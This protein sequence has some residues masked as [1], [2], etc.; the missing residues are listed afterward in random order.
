MFSILN[1]TKIEKLSY[2]NIIHLEL[3]NNLFNKMV[4]SETTTPNTLS[5]IRDLEERRIS[6]SSD[7][8]RGDEETGVWS[9]K[10]NITFI[11]SRMKGYGIGLITFVRYV[12][13]EIW[14]VLDGGNRCRALRDFYN[15]VFKWDGKKYDELSG[16]ERGK[17]DY[18]TM[19]CEKLTIE[20]GDPPDT[21][22]EMFTRLNTSSKTLSAGELCKAHGYRRNILEIEV[23]KKIVGGDA[24]TNSSVTD[25][26]IDAIRVRW[27]SIMG[28]IT[29]GNRC[30]SLKT[31]IG[32]IM[33]AILKKLKVFSPTDAYKKWKND[34][35]IIGDF[36]NM[37]DT[38]NEKIDK[39]VEKFNSFLENIE[40]MSESARDFIFKKKSKGFTRTVYIS[41]IWFNVINENIQQEDIVEF[42]NYMAVK[43][44]IQIKFISIMSAKDNHPTT[45]KMTKLALL[46]EDSHS[47][48]DSDSEIDSE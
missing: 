6:I 22:A 18:M 9:E 45:A 40:S 12:D 31:I 13:E 10:M 34:F 21:I 44:N 29:E 24:W 2:I 43:P 16:D 25:A 26:R 11:D 48:S 1:E 37:D 3:V 27:V 39:I 30:E 19:P 4:R 28:E 35:T 47:D 20:P 36:S 23:A 41:H 46:I 38:A 42:Y 8:Q 5:I 7:F 15:G 17:L 32:Y 33:S 14:S